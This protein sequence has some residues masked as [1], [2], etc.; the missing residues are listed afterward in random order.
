MNILMATTTMKTQTEITIPEDNE[1]FYNMYQMPYVYMFVN[2]WEDDEGKKQKKIEKI[3]PGW[4]KWNYI[5]CMEYNKTADPKCNCLMVNI[6][7]SKFCC[8]DIDDIDKMEE[9]MIKFG[10]THWFASVRQD[11]PHLYRIKHEKDMDCKN[12]I[13]KT[14]TKGYDIIYDHMLEWRNSEIQNW[15]TALLPTYKSEKRICAKK[16]PKIQTITFDPTVL[17]DYERAVLDNIDIKYWEYYDDWFKLVNVIVKEKQ[18]IAI[19]DEYSKKA[20]TYGGIEDVIAKTSNAMKLDYSWGTVMYYSKLSNP[21][22]YQKILNMYHIDIDLTDVGVAIMLMKMTPDDYVFQ[23]SI[24]YY[25]VSSNPFW[26]YDDDDNGVKHKIYID[27]LD[28]YNQK[29]LQVSQKYN[30]VSTEITDLERVKGKQDKEK[31]AAKYTLKLKLEEERDEIKKGVTHAKTNNRLSN[32]VVAL[33]QQLSTPRKRIMFDTLRPN[34]FC[35]QNCNI[36]VVTKEKVEIEKKDY[37]T[38]QVAYDFIEATEEQCRE[39]ESIIEKILPDKENRYSYMSAL[40]CSMLGRQIE[41]FLI[42]TGGGRNGKGVINELFAA[43]LTDI[44][45]YKANIT[46]LTE[47]LKGGANQELAN[48]DGKRFVL[49]SEPN[50]SLQLKLGNIKSLTGDTVINA[51]ALYSKKTDVSMTNMTI[52]ECNNIPR[53]EGRIDASA[54]ERFMI[55]DFPATF[56]NDKQMLKMKNCYPL[57]TRYKTDEF[58][59]EFKCAL[60]QYLLSFDFTEI[61]LPDCVRARTKRY[62]VGCDDFLTWFNE[63]Y[64]KTDNDSDVVKMIDLHSH[65]RKGEMWDT[66]PKAERRTKWNKEKMI[67][68]VKQNICLGFYFKESYKKKKIQ[69]SKCLTNFKKR[70]Q[71]A[72]EDYSD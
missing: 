41:K 38:K 59:Q 1:D 39:L 2:I 51:R 34:V 21:E 71:F 8:I 17:S 20:S 70:E 36:D 40:W 66:I 31:I 27:L 45:Y 18:N 52:L 44:Y 23:D 42:A 13:D 29:D 53:I 11:L 3:P 72:I 47:N 56:T 26:R 30:K 24:L 43:L 68:F 28:F 19:A 54:A 35:F 60:F 55:I 10:E 64:E 4:K 6:R 65:F 61:Y 48:M 7:G 16:K 12:V 46:C 69:Y 58:K 67:I 49:A 57:N 50:D 5:K 63:N 9:I 33:K 15:Y 37:I 25:C 22:E 62:L 32:Y 14:K